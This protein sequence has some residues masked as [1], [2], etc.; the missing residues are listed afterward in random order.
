MNILFQFTKER[1]FLTTDEIAQAV[2][3]PKSSAYR[4][5][6][7][8]KKLGLVDRDP[9]TGRYSLGLKLLELEE[10]V[11]SSIN[12]ES[13]AKPL[14]VKLG[15]FSGET[16]QL[17]MLHGDH[18]ICLYG[19]ESPSA[20]RLAPEKGRIIPLHAGASGLSILAFMDQEGQEKICVGPLPRFTP[21]TIT[22]PERLKARLGEFRKQGYVITQQEVYIGSLGIAAP[23]FGKDKRV[24]G[25]VS[26]SGPIQRISEERK[27]AI[28][29]E[30]VRTAK[31]ITDKMTMF[32]Y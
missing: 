16:V 12:L 23:V 18:G 21:Y 27:N 28:R 20:F 17:N 19:V 4:F 1:P 31:E 9:P 3:L 6:A 24:I 11:H 5:L 29:D 32:N 15:E 14:L 2:H 26:L 22:D 10:A 25:S 8:L 7:N 13:I 30:L